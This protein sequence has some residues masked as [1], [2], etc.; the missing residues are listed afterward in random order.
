MFTITLH[1][2]TNAAFIAGY[3]KKGRHYFKMQ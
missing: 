2:I 1:H 3:K